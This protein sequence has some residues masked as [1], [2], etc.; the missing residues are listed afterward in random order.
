MST[1][2]SDTFRETFNSESSA[3]FPS[4]KLT[5]LPNEIKFKVADRGGNDDGGAEE[6]PL[7]KLALVASAWIG[8]QCLWTYEFSLAQPYLE[9]LGMSADFAA[10]MWIW[11]PITGERRTVSCSRCELVTKKM[12][13][14]SL[15][16]PF[17]QDLLSLRW[18][19]LRR[20]IMRVD[21]GG[22]DLS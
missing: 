7:W 8:I 1:P 20:I 4:L 18:L 19:V 16:L 6:Y 2:A 21:L 3:E 5:Y 10:L 12:R 13:R 14:L 15:I 17:R 11:G 9:Y 22:E